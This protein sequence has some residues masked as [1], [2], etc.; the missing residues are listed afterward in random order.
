[1]Q[2]VDR[3]QINRR[4]GVKGQQGRLQ[5]AAAEVGGIFGYSLVVLKGVSAREVLRY[6]LYAKASECSFFFLI[7]LHFYSACLSELGGKK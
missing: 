5:L 6:S 3:Y 7:P 4:M 1:M 2:T